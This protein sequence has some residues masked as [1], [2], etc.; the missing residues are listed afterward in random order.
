MQFKGP[1][2]VT[3]IQSFTGYGKPVTLRHLDAFGTPYFLVSHKILRRNEISV[4]SCLPVVDPLRFL[5]SQFHVGGF[6]IYFFHIVKED[7]C[8]CDELD[9]SFAF[10]ELALAGQVWYSSLHT[11]MNK[12]NKA[13]L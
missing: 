9:C 6:F 10:C 1:V 7:Q 8:L 3:P 12:Q 2:L 5:S 4:S 11:V 13:W